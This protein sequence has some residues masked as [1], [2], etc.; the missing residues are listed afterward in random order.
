MTA[1]EGS[2]RHSGKPDR[3][4]GEGF[5]F[6]KKVR[7]QYIKLAHMFSKRYI[8]IDG[9]LSPDKIHQLIWIEIQNWKK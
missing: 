3:I 6:Q 9:T 8:V 2:R 5:D 1:E 4:E 7:E